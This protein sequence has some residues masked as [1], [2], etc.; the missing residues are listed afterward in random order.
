[1]VNR[2]IR[3]DEEALARWKAAA[4]VKLDD[5]GAAN[6]AVRMAADVEADEVHSEAYGIRRAL[7]WVARGHVNLEALVAGDVEVTVG[8]DLEIHTRVGGNRLIVGHNPVNHI[9][10]VERAAG[11]VK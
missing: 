9:R 3:I 1:M 11:L 4:G 6:A 7:D 8:E 10:R 2:A 5:N